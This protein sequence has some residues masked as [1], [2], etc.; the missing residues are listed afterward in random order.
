MTDET[1]NT[2][3]SPHT[4]MAEALGVQARLVDQRRAFLAA[5]LAAERSIL[6]S[7]N[8]YRVADVDAYFDACA[9][10]KKAPRPR[11]YKWRK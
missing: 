10:E 5:A 6:E 11:L 3:K 4:F 7:G 9:A 8:G 2:G 1:K